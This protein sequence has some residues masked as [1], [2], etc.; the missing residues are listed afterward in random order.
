M[1]D[2]SVEDLQQDFCDGIK[3]CALM[4]SLQVRAYGYSNVITVTVVQQV[5]K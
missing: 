1:D 3:L 4:E 2:L 5:L